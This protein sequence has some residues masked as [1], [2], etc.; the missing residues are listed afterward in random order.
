MKNDVKEVL[1]WQF[2]VQ[3]SAYCGKSVNF[4]LGKATY[5]DEPFDILNLNMLVHHSHCLDIVLA[6]VTSAWCR[7]PLLCECWCSKRFPVIR[8][9][10]E[11]QPLVHSAIP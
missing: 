2:I 6:Y 3:D 10:S 8:L 1:S 7:E 5:F 9:T 11:S 4:N